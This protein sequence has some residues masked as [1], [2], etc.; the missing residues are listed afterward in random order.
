MAVVCSSVFR[1]A[2]LPSEARHQDT[3]LFSLSSFHSLV[4]ELL[5]SDSEVALR[6]AVAS[7]FDEFV[8]GESALDLRGERNRTVRSHG[9]NY[10]FY[11]HRAPEMKSISPVVGHVA[12]DEVSCSQSRHQGELPRQH[13]A[14]HH[15]GQLTGVLTRLAGA[16]ALNTE[17]LQTQTEFNVRER[18]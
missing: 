14:A 15:P 12:L 3:V 17:H 10:D 16:G 13:G 2:E 6:H 18:R 8:S 4:E 11:Q 5:Q 9:E 1:P 7:D